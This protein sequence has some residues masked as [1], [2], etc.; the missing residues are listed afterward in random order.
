MQ[1]QNLYHY[2]GWGIAITLR[3]YNDKLGMSSTAGDEEFLLK[4]SSILKEFSL[5]TCKIL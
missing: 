2:G 5:F 4:N 1:M 3:P